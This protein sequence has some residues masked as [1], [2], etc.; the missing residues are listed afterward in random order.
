MAVLCDGGAAA[1]FSFGTTETGQ[2]N[3]IHRDS[4]LAR[5][6]R[7]VAAAYDAVVRS[8]STPA[9]AE[10]RQEQR[11]WRRFAQTVCRKTRGGSA[12]RSRAYCLEDLYGLRKNELE[13][14]VSKTGNIVIRRVARY[15][16]AASAGP[17][18]GGAH[19]G[20]NTTV[21]EFPQIENPVNQREKAWNEL[22]AH[23][24]HRGEPLTTVSATA[25]T[26]ADDDRDLLVDYVLGSASPGMIS[27][28]LVIY[29]DGHG[30]HGTASEECI[31]W[32]LGEG[33]ALRSEDVF[34]ADRSWDGVL[35]SV[36]LNQNQGRVNGISADLNPSDIV[37]QVRDPRHWLIGEHEL[38]VRFIVE[39]A[40][41]CCNAVQAEIPWRVLKPYLKSPLPFSTAL[42]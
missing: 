20:L 11:Q 37:D 8:L 34:D 10:L 13:D 30:A 32:L 21:I 36:V 14:T 4:A 2:E 22:I 5:A 7:K 42:D 18:S 24:K 19:P 29:D 9:R 12:G 38:T 33:R 28:W 26:S 1:R 17:G 39:G 41:S 40:P 15:S 35:A 27:L 25:S 16:F 23:Y 31:N 6:G 3:L